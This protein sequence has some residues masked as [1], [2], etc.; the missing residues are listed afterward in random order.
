MKIDI[1]AHLM[2]DYWESL[3]E[4]FGYGGFIRLEHHKAGAAR[5]MR[6]DGTFFREVQQNCWDPEWVLRDMDEH[7]VDVM[8]LY[9]VPVLFSYFAQPMH[10]LEWSMYLNDHLATIMQ[11][12]PK[13][14]VALGTAPMQDVEMAIQEMTRCVQELGLPGLQIG[15][16]I[17]GMNLDDKR[18]FP[19]YKAAEELGCC[20]IVHPWEMAGADRMERY[21]NKWLVGMPGETALALTSMIFGGVFDAFPKLRVLFS[22][23]GGAFPFTLGR[24]SHGWHARPDLCNVNNIQ[25]PREYVGRFWVD[26]IT[27][28]LPAFRYLLEVMG[29]DHIC[30]GTDY[31]FPL[32]DLEHGKFLEQSG[33]DPTVLQ[34]VFAENALRFLN[35][36]ASRFA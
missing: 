17:N 30:Y 33:I 5:M 18:L 3:K 20:L 16:N 13:R 8:V 15:S 22:H 25:D 28:D 14:M 34:K 2:P 1:H 19:F 26:G 32:G 4:K 29:E 7:E 35:L 23:A 31:P 9:T 6:D 21:F 10:G 11:R 24:I 27:H 36:P 12:Y